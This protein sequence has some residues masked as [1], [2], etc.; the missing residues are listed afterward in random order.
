ML[1]CGW[2]FERGSYI[3]SKRELPFERMFERT[4]VRARSNV[5]SKLELRIRTYVRT[6]VCSILGQN[7]R[8]YVRIRIERTYVRF[9]EPVFERMFERARADQKLN[10]KVV[11]L[12]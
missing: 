6:N 9:W 5:C 3:C 2:A 11:S 10:K 12:R 4:Y 8:T 1:K 7:I